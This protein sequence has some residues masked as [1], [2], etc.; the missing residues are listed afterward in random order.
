MGGEYIGGSLLAVVSSPGA[1]VLL[2]GERTS[3][4]PSHCGQSFGTLTGH[5]SG[6]SHRS[7]DYTLTIASGTFTI[8]DERHRRRQVEFRRGDV[9]IDLDD[10]LWYFREGRYHWVW[11][12]GDDT[13]E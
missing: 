5:S 1:A 6:K 9:I 8:E 10:K 4:R 2:R 13:S 11:D 3:E 7:N 12:V